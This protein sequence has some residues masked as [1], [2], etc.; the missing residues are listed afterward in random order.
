MYGEYAVKE[1]YQPQTTGLSM[2]AF[3]NLRKRALDAGR[4]KSNASSLSN[5]NARESNEPA[6]QT[7]MF[8]APLKN[9]T[10]PTLIDNSKPMFPS[11]DV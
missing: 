2:S 8:T 4:D 5:Q 7:S 1:A 6:A 9:I 3:A 10:Q 11:L